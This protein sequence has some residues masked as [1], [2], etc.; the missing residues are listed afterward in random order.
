MSI[1]I[2]CYKLDVIQG[3]L[4]SSIESKSLIIAL[5]PEAASYHCRTLPVNQFSV[6]SRESPTFP[7]GTKYVLLDAGG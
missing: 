5:E 7:P 1:E 3:G 4:T 2:Y 6:R